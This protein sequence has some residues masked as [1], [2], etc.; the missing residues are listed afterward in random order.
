MT[1]TQ[2]PTGQ[3]PTSIAM[4]RD[5]HYINRMPATAIGLSDIALYIPKPRIDLKTI[6]DRRIAD[7]PAQARRLPRAIDATGQQAIRFPESWEDSASLAG[8]AALRLLRPQD[9][10]L[11]GPDLSRFRHLAVGTETGLDFSKPLSAYVSGMLRQA[12]FPLP[13]TH[14]SFQVQHA[15]A[16]GTIAMMSVAS[17]LAVSGSATDAGLVIC[18]DIARY[19]VPSSAEFT[20]GAGALALL[21]EK[22]PRLV[23]IDLATPGYSSADVDDF[24]RPLDST[25]AKVKGQYSMQCYN[26][27][28]EQAF[29]DHCRQL[30][31]DQADVLRETDIFVFHVPFAKMAYTAARQLLSQHL[32]IIDGEVDEFLAKRHFFVPLETTA[33]VG[34]IYTGASFLNLRANLQEAYRHYGKDI[35]GK[36]ILF[37][38]YGSGNTMIVMSM[39][40]QPDAPAVIASWPVDEALAGQRTVGFDEYLSWVTNGARPASQ[41][42]TEDG[43][44]SGLCYLRAIREDGYREYGVKS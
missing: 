37:T 17:L 13:V 4:T 18:S 42:G 22:S 15:C 20:Q 2:H 32:G 8:N 40:V 41:N 31:R 38:S 35:V 29:A 12:G 36:R 26:T 33:A 19:Q 6:L 28:A 5:N 30:G 43:I 25:I 1:S 14:S 9:S 21:V 34:N 10:G 11:P 27:A 24:F 16:G 7:D 44:P 3:N 23:S 39:T